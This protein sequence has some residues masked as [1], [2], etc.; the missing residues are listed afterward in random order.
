MS[1][2]AYSQ[3]ASVWLIRHGESK[4]QVSS[5]STAR[6]AASSNRQTDPLLRD[7]A[8]TRFGVR[9]AKAAGAAAALL[10]LDLILVSP[11]SRV[12]ETALLMCKGGGAAL[13]NVALVVLPALAEKG[14]RAIENQRRSITELR[15]DARLAALPR[16]S[17]IDFTIVEKEERR[18]VQASEGSAAATIRR[19]I[20]S[21]GAQRIAVVGHNN[22]FV[23]LVR[24]ACIP[25]F[26]NAQAV[27]CRSC[28]ACAL[29]LPIGAFAGHMCAAPATGATVARQGVVR[30]GVTMRPTSLARQLSDDATALFDVALGSIS[31]AQR[32]LVRAAQ[33][34]RAAREDA[35]A[36]L[37]RDTR[38]R[39]RRARTRLAQRVDELKRTDGYIAAIAAVNAVAGG[40]V[41]GGGGRAR[42][43]F[44]WLECGESSRSSLVLHL[45]PLRGDVA[46]AGAGGGPAWQAPVRALFRHLPEGGAIEPLHVTLVSS[47]HLTSAGRDRV[48]AALRAVQRSGSAPAPPAVRFDGTARAACRGAKCTV[49]LRL[50]DQTAWARYA[51][52]VCSALGVACDAE[53]LFHVSCWNG[54][55]GDPFRS[56]GDVGARDDARGAEFTRRFG[57][58]RFGARGVA[59]SRTKVSFLL[60]TVTFYANLAHSLTRSP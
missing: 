36:V 54:S 40:A 37:P 20:A 30:G 24:P 2:G 23:E 49:F 13:A 31:P 34:E 59:Q 53:R 35:I 29:L 56:V 5:K 51:A 33:A 43:R 17:S 46:D 12:I 3:N 27:P 44:C 32:E 57:R 41:H 22:R 21:S 52:T 48:R 15:A 42:R 58:V 28:A 38:A 14:S 45:A 10:N 1:A 55:G 4:A 50:A 39:A 25:R 16:F 26:R 9:Q 47:Q 11:L 60:C 8:L 7:C 19:W 6:Q 18:A